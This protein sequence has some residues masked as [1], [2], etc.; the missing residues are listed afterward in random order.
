M[1]SLENYGVQ[2]LT[3]SSSRLTQ[4][5][6]PTGY[7]VGKFFGALLKYSGPYGSSYF[8]VDYTISKM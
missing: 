2:E 8:L 4:A 6:T 7:D 3:E 1:K 5:G